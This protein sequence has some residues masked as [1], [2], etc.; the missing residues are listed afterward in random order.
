M[1]THFNVTTGSSTNAAGINLP[2]MHG[3]QKG[4]DPTSNL[5]ANQNLNKHWPNQI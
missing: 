4:I 5:K 1:I 3:P 2:P